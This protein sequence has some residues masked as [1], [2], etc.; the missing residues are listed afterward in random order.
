MVYSSI[1]RLV[2]HAWKGQEPGQ[3]ELPYRGTDNGREQTGTPFDS[4][5]RGQVQKGPVSKLTSHALRRNKGGERS[6]LQQP[7]K[8]SLPSTVQSQAPWCTIPQDCTQQ[9]R[10]NS[11]KENRVYLYIYT[12]I[13]PRVMLKGTSQRVLL[14][15]ES[16]P[17]SSL[18]VRPWDVT[19]CLF[20]LL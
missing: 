19:L 13:R 7:P 5:L 18:S 15:F 11:Q 6:C 3:Q 12:S 10:G 14:A 9:G 8:T 20:P 1:E 4:P 2:I 17:Q 16:W